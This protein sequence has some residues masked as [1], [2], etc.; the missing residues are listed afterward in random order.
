MRVLVV[1]D[2]AVLRADLAEALTASGFAVETVEDGESAWFLGDTE[3]FD[4]VVL[5]LGLPFRDGLSVLKLWRGAGNRMP[6]I[7]LS[8]RGSWMERVEGIDAGAD[9]YLAKPFEMVELVSRLRALT[10]RAA[11]QAAAVLTCGPLVIDTRRMSAAVNG[12]ALELSPLEYRLLHYLAHHG[13]RIVPP[14]ELAEHVYGDADARDP[15]ALEALI[16]RLRRKTGPK[17]IE[18]RR[19]FGYGLAAGA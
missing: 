9:D 19:G 5:D 7:V 14:A 17:V 6:V 8:A 13:E 18:T 11:G 16:A 12:R 15:N 3:T 10:R 1:E 4:A 2:D